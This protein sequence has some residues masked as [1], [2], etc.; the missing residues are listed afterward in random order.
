MTALVIDCSVAICW[1]YEHEG[2][3]LTHA[4][5]R[6]VAV[7]TAV[8]PALLCL[9]IANVLAT[10]L[11]KKSLTED[12][13]TSYVAQLQR[14][15]WELEPLDLTRSLGSILALAQK[16]GLTSYD[17]AYLEMAKRRELPLATH[18]KDLAAAAKR[19]RVKLFKAP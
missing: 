15:H 1:C 5:L 6:H 3:D 4:A 19:E 11:R 7:H 8:A 9:E 10:N 17:A 16:H 2:S 14:L 12:R 13:L 18:D